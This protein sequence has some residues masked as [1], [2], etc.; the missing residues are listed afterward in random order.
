MAPYTVR[1]KQALLCNYW[2]YLCS[3]LFK[4]YSAISYFLSFLPLISLCGYA[5]VIFNPQKTSKQ[6]AFYRRRT[7]F[8]VAIKRAYIGNRNLFPSTALFLHRRFLFSIEKTHNAWK[9]MYSQ[10]HNGMPLGFVVHR[11]FG[12][13]RSSSVSPFIE[14]QIWSSWFLDSKQNK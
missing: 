1:D 11:V 14:L 3:K 6:T 12:V 9:C 10:L 2:F 8:R 5:E 4:L 7:C 13:I